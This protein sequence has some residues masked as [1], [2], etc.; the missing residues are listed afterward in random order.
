MV[1]VDAAKLSTKLWTVEEMDFNEVASTLALNRSTCVV[2]TRER[3]R[4][5]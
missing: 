3:S 4:V 5:F 2:A 1:A